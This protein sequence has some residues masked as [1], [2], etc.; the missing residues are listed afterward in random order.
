MV[1][2][3]RKKLFASLMPWIDELGVVKKEISLLKKK[4]K[5]LE[6]K[7]QPV[8]VREEWA[9][10]EGKTFKAERVPSTSTEVPL[11]VTITLLSKL[12]QLNR[13]YDVAKVGLTA[14]RDIVG[15]EAVAE[16]EKVT[17]DKT[18]KFKISPIL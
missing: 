9:L 4:E 6:A 10:I 15:K 17:V 5:K 12:G 7:I 1:K 2:Q 3:T 11:K 16:I 13:L 18:G 8:M 14:L